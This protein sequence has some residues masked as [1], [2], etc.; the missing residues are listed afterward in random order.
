MAGKDARKKTTSTPQERSLRWQKI[1]FGALALII[2]AS[3][4]VTLVIH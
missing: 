2:I 3:W 4:L 1:L